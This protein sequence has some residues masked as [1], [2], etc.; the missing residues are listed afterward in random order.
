LIKTSASDP[1]MAFNL[2]TVYEE[3]L[4]KELILLQSQTSLTDRCKFAQPFYNCK[5]HGYDSKVL[6]M[7]K[8]H[9]DKCELEKPICA[10][11]GVN[12]HCNHGKVY[13][14]KGNSEKVNYNKANSEKPNYNKEN[15]GKATY[16]V[17]ILLIV[18]AFML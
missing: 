9:Q 13:Y 4:R 18:L 2:R 8:E 16:G 7:Q 10:E 11:F 5:Y 17:V 12:L 1:F 6:E 14:S 3:C 15:S